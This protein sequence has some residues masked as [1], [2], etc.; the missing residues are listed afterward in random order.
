MD[1]R[2]RIIPPAVQRLPSGKL[3]PNFEYA[4]RKY[5]G[6]KWTLQ[7]REKYP[8]GVIFTDDGFPDFSPYARHVVTIDPHFT[9]NRDRDEREANKRAGLSVTPD[10]YTWHHHQDG[11]TLLLVPFMLHFAVRH[12]GG[13][14]LRKGKDQQ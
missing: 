3:P 7:L 10:G 4:G 2:G 8:D 1:S 11:K 14:A 5:D 13:V 12:A 6:P 9:G